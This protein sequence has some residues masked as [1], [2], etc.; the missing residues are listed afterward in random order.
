MWDFLLSG[1]NVLFMAALVLMLLIGIAEASGLGSGVIGDSVDMEADLDA[2]LDGGAPTLL[3]WLNVGRLSLLMLIVIL[4]LAFGVL[5]LLGQQAAVA[6]LGRPAPALIAVP[7]ALA[8]ALPVTR[9]LSR[10]LSRVLPRDETTAVSRASLVGRTA[11]I[12]TGQA[13]HADAAQARVHDRHGQAHYVMVEPDK[14]TD[15]F[16]EGSKVLLVRCEGARYFAILDT[17]ALLAD[18]VT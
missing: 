16:A 5:G 9:Y 13:R 15:V 1:D 6:L 12:V 7:A 10:W 11:V 8:A 14:I 3:A 18:A 2:E 17:G 4:L